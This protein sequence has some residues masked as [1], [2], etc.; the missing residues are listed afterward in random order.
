MDTL[1]GD[2]L[3]SRRHVVGGL[4]AALVVAALPAAPAY[5]A[6]LA[7]RFAPAGRSTIEVDHGPWATLLDRYL[8]AGADGINRIAYRA[9]KAGGKSTLSA[10]LEALQTVDPRRLDRAD[11]AAFWINLY[12]A[13]TVAVV[14]DRYPVASIRDINLGGSLIGRGPWR[15]KLVTVAGTALSLDDIEHRILRP[16]LGEPR[17]HYAVNCAAISCP[18]LQPRAFTGATIEK[19]LAAGARAYVNHRRGLRVE[20]GRIYA[21]SIYDWYAADFGGVTGV[22]RH[23]RRYAEPGLAAAV[24]KAGGSIEYGY[25]WSLNDAG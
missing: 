23:W 22:R 15:K 12:N 25:D 18:N 20:A 4:A 3:R 1:P 11:Q 7:A 21:S 16:G 2:F 19:L 8:V 14:I 5:A 10:Y 9:F 24:K 13:A 6:G 17:I